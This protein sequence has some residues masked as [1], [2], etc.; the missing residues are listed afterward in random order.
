MWRRVLGGLPFAAVIAAVL[1]CAPAASAKDVTITSFD[2]TKIA[3]HWF[4]GNGVGAGARAPTILEGPGWSQGGDTQ[5]EGGS[6]AGAI[7]G[8]P[9]I[10]NFISHGYNVLTWDPRGFGQSGG[11]V[12]IDDPRYEGR[13]VQALID[14]VAKQPE[15]Q[16]DQSCSTT[17]KRAKKKRRAKR[18]VTCAV[19][20]NDPTIGMAGASY[21]GGIQL[22][23]AGL[24]KRIDAI[25]PTIAWH[26]LLTSLFPEGNIKLGWG[27]ILEGIGVEGTLP[28]GLNAPAT[29]AG[30]QD[31]HFYSI[32][33]NG[34]AT[35]TTPQDDLDWMASHGPGD[36]LNRIQVPTLIMQ[37]TVDTLFPL[38]EGVANFDQI[39][40]NPLRTAAIKAKAKKKRKGK[41]KRGRR[42]LAP[43][44]RVP[45]K[46][47][48]FCGGHGVCLTGAGDG[49]NYLDQRALAWFDRYLRGRADTDTGP[50]F[51]WI[52]DDAKVRGSDAYPLNPAGQLHASGSGTLPIVPG[53]GSGGLIFA[54]AAPIAVNL[55]VPGPSSDA[56]VVGAPHLDLTY[57]GTAAPQKTWVYAQFV[58]P[59][60][61]TVLGN[62]A[63]PIP[64]TLDGHAHSISRD[65]EM[66]AGRAPAGG[67]YT[68]QLTPSSSLFDIQRSAGAVTFNSI[69]VTKPLGDPATGASDVTAKHHKK[70]HRKRK[71][72][73]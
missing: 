61:G 29:A 73:H 43:V 17:K 23:A 8:V 2:G 67:G 63:T 69:D 58:N 22:V 46:M 4:V 1:A 64:V 70:K 15:A 53:Q 26:S 16:M 24:D 21:G 71:H 38:E 59:R 72:R 39:G 68:L 62:Q 40:N 33:T 52:A 55:A 65:L 49:S 20:P 56:N 9:G 41:R 45:V 25:A 42:S 57:Q 36:L 60:N 18:Q 48:W 34:L 3:A 5:S 11:T 31:P 50:K 47:I 37:G 12:E 32:L 30:R 27:S 19:S 54:T 66:V 35:G 6:G 51:A 44:Q 13:D 28:G 7:F 10:S 14:W